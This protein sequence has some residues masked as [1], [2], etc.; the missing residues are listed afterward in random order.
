M[1]V[2]SQF[3]SSTGSGCGGMKHLAPPSRWP[4]WNLKERCARF[5]LLALMRERVLLYDGAMGT[6]LQRAN[7]EPDDFAGKEGCNELLC[8]TRPDVVS[9]IHAQ[10]FAAG[11]D[12][13]ETNSFGSTPVVLAEYGIAERSYDLSR[14]AAE[15]ASAVAHDFSTPDQ[16]RFVSGSVGPT[17]KLVSLGH[18]SFHELRAAFETQ[19][20]G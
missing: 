5:P 10:Y 15:L 8:E 19:I 13:S 9:G 4:R 20:R 6:M 18:I 16:P 7:L 3:T 12:L 2:G 1:C 17:T 14:R 11:A